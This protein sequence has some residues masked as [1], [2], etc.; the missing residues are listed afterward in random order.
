MDEFKTQK[1]IQEILNSIIYRHW[2]VE[3]KASPPPVDHLNV[4]TSIKTTIVV[5]IILNVTAIIIVIAIT[6]IIISTIIIIIII[7]CI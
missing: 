4:V 7:I 3:G 1:L 6:I 5:F 2:F